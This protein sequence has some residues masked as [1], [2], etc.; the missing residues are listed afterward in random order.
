M[1]FNLVFQTHISGLEKQVTNLAW[2]TRLIS[3]SEFPNP[4]SSLVNQ[5]EIV[6]SQTRHV[7]QSGF[8]NKPC[9]L[10]HQMRA[11]GGGRFLVCWSGFSGQTQSSSAFPNCPLVFQTKPSL[12]SKHIYEAQLSVLNT[13]FEAHLMQRKLGAPWNRDVHANCGTHPPAP[14]ARSE[15]PGGALGM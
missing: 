4:P 2:I 10:E 13:W 12:F 9:A 6:F 7:S 11:K 14:S 3:V 5:L 15:A 1:L 8:P